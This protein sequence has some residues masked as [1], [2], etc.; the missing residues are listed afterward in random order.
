MTISIEQYRRIL[1]LGHKGLV[2]SAVYEACQRKSS[3]S[4]DYVDNFNISNY[5]NVLHVISKSNCD[6]VINCIG[7][8]NVDMAEKE[9]KM[10][11][12]INAIGAKNVAIACANHKVKMIH[13]STDFVFDGTL[14]RPY[15]ESDYPSP[16]S[17]YGKSK[18][19]GDQS[20]LEILPESII[21]RSAWIFGP[22]RT[23]FVDKILEKTRDG[24]AINVVDDQVG[25]PTYSLELSAAI[26]YMIFAGYCGVINICNLGSASR[27]QLAREI[28]IV[29]G[30]DPDLV[31]P[32]NSNQLDSKLA[33]RPAYSVLDTEKCQNITGN[34]MSDWRAA[35]RDYVSNKNIYVTN[36]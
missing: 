13:L 19:L 11:Y 30:R 10:A 7:Y 2:G 5:D 34:K 6:Y 14:N 32:I 33:T 17:V 22:Y 18:L 3:V 26:L 23:N 9:K 15:K 35:L 29:A 27:F 1:V 4:C 16:L 36:K 24:N 31:I 20:V 28:L 8:T 21:V 25:S 12:S